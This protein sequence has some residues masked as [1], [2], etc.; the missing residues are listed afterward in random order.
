MWNP[1][2]MTQTNLFTTEKQTHRHRKQSYGSQRERGRDK[3]EYEINRCTL[4]YIKY[5]NNKDLLYSTGDCIQYIIINYCSGK[6]YK[7]YMCVYIYNQ[8]IFLYS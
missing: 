4:L 7:V 6:N 2:K 3:L 5:K 1:R 8:I